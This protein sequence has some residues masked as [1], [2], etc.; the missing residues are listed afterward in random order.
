MGGH[1][2]A[3]DLLSIQPALLRLV[4]KYSERIRFQFWGIDPPPSL[5]PHS[6]VDWYPIPSS[7]YSDFVV[8]FQ[9]Q[10]MDIAIAPLGDNLFNSCKSAIKFFDYTALGAPGVYSR[11][12]PYTEVIEHGKE[13]FLASTPDEWVDCLSR[14]I[15]NPDLRKEIVENA[16]RQIKQNWLLSKNLTNRLDVYSQLASTYQPRQKVYPDSFQM[17]K[18]ITRQVYEEHV[19]SYDQKQMVQYLNKRAEEQDQAVLSLGNKVSEQEG[20]IQTKNQHLSDLE[21][22]VLSYATSSS[23]KLTRPLRKILRKW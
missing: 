11:V 8:Y 12:V 13:G 20:I 1:S 3:P 4:D 15:E 7:R 10:Q 18:T 21:D 2:H 23:W 9:Q 16:Q 19:R 14:L 6:R 5:V 17:L 22:E